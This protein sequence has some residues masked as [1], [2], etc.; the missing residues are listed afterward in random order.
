[1][2]RA[3]VKSAIFLIFLPVLLLGKN[4]FDYSKV[5]QGDWAV[6]LVRGL[7][8]DENRELVNIEDFTK[9]LS[10][11]NITPKNGWQVG[12]YLDYQ[13]VAGTIGLALIHLNSNGSKK[14][15]ADFSKFLSFL[16]NKIGISINQLQVALSKNE[17]LAELNKGIDQYLS[18]KEAES[19]S[20]NPQSQTSNVQASSETRQGSSNNSNPTLAT[21][22]VVSSLAEALTIYN[23]GPTNPDYWEVFSEPASPILP[24]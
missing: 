8:L 7:N 15:T 23:A 9:L 3:S 17:N 16:E 14:K 1:M 11:N 21:A 2:I 6:V 12:N 18:E 5:H 13:D 10:E 4:E 19:P 24:E 22:S 20:E